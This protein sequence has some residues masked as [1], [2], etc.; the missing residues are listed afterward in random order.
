M[1]LLPPPG[2]GATAKG[3]YRER[4]KKKICE[5]FV[6]TYIYREVFIIK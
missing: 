5:N 4:F 2:H 1:A 6:A 3:T